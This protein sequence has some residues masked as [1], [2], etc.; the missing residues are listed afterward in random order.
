MHGQHLLV[1]RRP[2]SV[3]AG[4]HAHNREAVALRY[5]SA[6]GF[7][8]RAL[9]VVEVQPGADTVNYNILLYYGNQ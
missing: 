4:V 7:S 1:G 8:T 9:P 6:H 5:T 3:P 2:H